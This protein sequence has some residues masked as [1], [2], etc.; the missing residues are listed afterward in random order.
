MYLVDLNFIDMNKITPALTNR[1]RQ[2][3]ENEY[4]SSLL[5]F[6]GR[7]VPRTG[8]VLISAHPTKEAL[9]DVLESDPF[10]VSGAASYVIT[11]FDP[12]MAS[13]RYKE[14]I[15]QANVGG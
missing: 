12:V 11:E 2:H 7:K 4:K 9:I 14:I 5:M 6:G 8:G 1:H 15:E 13:E 3:L 10:I